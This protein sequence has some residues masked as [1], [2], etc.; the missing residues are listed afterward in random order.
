M[1]PAFVVL[2]D[3]SSSA[4]AALLYT[5]QLARHVNGRVVLLHVYLDPLLE[6]EVSL[7]PAT[8]QVASRQEIM[9]NMAK[10]TQQL[11]VPALI[12]LSDDS[13]EVAVQHMILRYHPLLLAAWREAP[14]TAVASQ[15]RYPLL[16]V[17]ETWTGAGLPR[18]VVVAADEQSFGLT[19]PALALAPLLQALQ[20]KTTLVHASPGRGPAP[21]D[22]ALLAVGRTGLFGGLTGS[23]VY[24][25]PEEAPA[26]GVLRAC[27]E[28]GAELL[29]VPARPHTLLGGVFHRSVTAELLRRSPIPVLVLPITEA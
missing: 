27:A 5:T 13:L 16:L 4:E 18:R 28:L 3:L 21:L 22:A 10:R 14:H 25:V 2:T 7:V 24:E 9:A 17:P 12:E 15:A 1:E 23:D 6:L 29:V 8:V 19:P 11:G 20:A 26:P